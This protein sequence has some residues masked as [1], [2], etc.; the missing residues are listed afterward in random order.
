M[1]RAKLSGLEQ[2]KKALASENVA[3]QALRG[4][5]D[6]L[7]ETMLATEARLIALSDQLLQKEGELAEAKQVCVGAARGE[8]E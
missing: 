5:R 2:D 7:K 4:E 1:C 6:A 3:L 8:G